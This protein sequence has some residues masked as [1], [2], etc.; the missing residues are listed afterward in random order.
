[1]WLQPTLAMCNTLIKGWA[2]T[3]EPGEV[4]AIMMNM[5][6]EG[7]QPD[8]VSW[9]GLVHAHAVAGQPGR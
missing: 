1:M 6:N 8:A 4:R 3:G 2:K 9:R 5:R 7:F